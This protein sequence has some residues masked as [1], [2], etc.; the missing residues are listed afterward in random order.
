MEELT[1]QE[2]A[3]RAV[4]IVADAEQIRLTFVVN[5]VGLDAVSLAIRDG[6]LATHRTPERGGVTQVVYL[7]AEP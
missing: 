7:T 6:R 2:R 5:Q 4:S 3:K 1:I